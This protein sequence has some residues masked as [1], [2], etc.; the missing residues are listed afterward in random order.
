MCEYQAFILARS[1]FAPLCSGGCFFYFDCAPFWGIVLFRWD[2]TQATADLRNTSVMR[3]VHAGEWNVVSESLRGTC[4]VDSTSE[5]I[6]SI[7]G[8]FHDLYW[9]SKKLS[10]CFSF[11]LQA[12]L[13]PINS[14]ELIYL[15][16][17]IF[18]QNWLKWFSSFSKPVDLVIESICFHMFNFIFLIQCD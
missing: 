12:D 10:T 15:N 11:L 1:R 16:R 14:T 3:I 8:I 17:F 4:S 5:N 6:M 13:L 7:F 18:P 2:V 9:F